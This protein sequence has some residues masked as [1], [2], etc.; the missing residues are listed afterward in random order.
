MKLI[1]ENTH[2]RPEEDV[3][4]EKLGELQDELRREV[5]LCVERIGEVE[6]RARVGVLKTDPEAFVGRDKV[7]VEEALAG[8]PLESEVVDATPEPVLVDEPI[9]SILPI[10]VEEPVSTSPIEVEEPIDVDEPQVS[11]LPVDADEPRVSILPVGQPFVHQE[12]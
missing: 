1:Q 11:I 5:A 3:L 12:L 10:D 8:V 9:V 7:E 4:N 2:P 6:S